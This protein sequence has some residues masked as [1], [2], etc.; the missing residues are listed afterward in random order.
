LSLGLLFTP[1]NNVAF[2]NLKPEEAQQ[3]SGLINLARQLGGSFGIAVLGSFLTRHI[4]Y[5]RAD[6]V[7]NLYPGNPAF[8]ERYDGLV[9]ALSGQGLSLVDAQQ[10]ALAILDATMMRQASMQAYN[11]AWLLLLMCFICVAPAV[12]LLRKPR[13]RQAATADGH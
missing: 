4:A 2:G 11:D 3:A 12:F 5:H 13:S 7:S 1:I 9:A 8:A 6:L 10:R